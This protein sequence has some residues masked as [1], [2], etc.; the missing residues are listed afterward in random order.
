MTIEREVSAANEAH[1]RAFPVSRLLS[2]GMAYED[3]LVPCTP[4][5]R[6]GKTGTRSPRKLGSEKWAACEDAIAAWSDDDRPGVASVRVSLLY[7]TVQAV[8]A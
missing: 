4:A 6:T 5:W 1:R 3:V 7:R 8:L 2:S